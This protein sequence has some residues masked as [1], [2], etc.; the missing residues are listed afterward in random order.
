MGMGAFFA[1]YHHRTMRIL[2]VDYDENKKARIGRAP[3]I[4]ERAKNYSGG[5]FGS[6]VNER[7]MNA[8][9][10]IAK[11]ANPE[12]KYSDLRSQNKKS[13]HTL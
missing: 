5:A 3:T 8:D 12:C 2:H 9:D 11:C 13:F 4:S 1:Y 7:K 10:C 6:K